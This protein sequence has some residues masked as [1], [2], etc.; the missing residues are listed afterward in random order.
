MNVNYREIQ[1]DLLLQST[2]NYL[3]AFTA[4]TEC[5]AIALWTTIAHIMNPVGIDC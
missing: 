3:F 2:S 1:S 4:E 5:C